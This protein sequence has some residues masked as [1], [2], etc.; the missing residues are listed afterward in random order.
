[1]TKTILF[2]GDSIT[3][4][5]RDRNDLLS[6]GSGY[7]NMLSHRLE[8][9]KVINLGISGNRTHDLV[10]RLHEVVHESPDIISILIGINDVW[11]K[12]EWQIETNTNEFKCH[13]TTILD[14]LKA[15]LQK[16]HVILVSPFILP[17]GAYLPGMRPDLD[18]EIRIL[19]DLSTRYQIPFVPLDSVFF[20]AM[21]TTPMEALTFDGV[22]PTEL[23]HKVIADQLEPVIKDLLLD[24]CH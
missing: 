1:M 14:A 5:N 7:V 13:M 17:M 9:H 21:R 10:S 20:E 19:S 8:G 4:A 16:A 6:L 22:H 18:E 15:S 2:F 11:H 24:D 12:H 23:G 3:D